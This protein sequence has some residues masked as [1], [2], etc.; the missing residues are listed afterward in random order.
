MFQLY[1]IYKFSFSNLKQV[2][3]ISPLI[4]INDQVKLAAYMEF[5]AEYYF[6]STNQIMNYIF[7]FG[8]DDYDYM[9][10]VRLC[11]RHASLAAS[12]DEAVKV[13]SKNICFLKL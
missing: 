9:D 3:L 1:C 10:F 4:D 8:E 11:G 12:W 6:K 7:P 2:P 13:S 5:D